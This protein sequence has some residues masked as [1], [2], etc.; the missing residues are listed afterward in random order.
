MDKI[1]KIFRAEV[2]S[3]DQEKKRAKVV[4]STDQTDRDGDVILPA[5]F[6]KDLK[7]YK[8]QPVLLSSHNYYSLMSQIGKAHDIKVNEGDV[9]A[10]F[11]WFANNIGADGKTMNPEADWG[12]LLMCKGIAAFSIGF[13]GKEYDY[14]EE[15]DPNTGERRITGRKFTRI[16][17]LEVSQVLIPSNRGAIQNSIDDSRTPVEAKE[18]C[19]LVLKAHKEGKIKNEDFPCE[20]NKLNDNKDGNAS[21]NSETISSHA[22]RLDAMDKQIS[23]LQASHDNMATDLEDLQSWRASFNASDDFIDP[24][25]MGNGS[26]NGGKGTIH[27]SRDLLKPKQDASKDQTVDAEID[28]I[29]DAFKN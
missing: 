24:V 10:D 25:A 15:K 9:I 17:L 27:Y 20:K 19:E 11:E 26:D 12:W 1:I 29:R 6:K 13:V 8:S 14:I 2:K 23:K 21:D 18:M 5:S 28:A 22:T 7:F 3:I 4:I 16:E